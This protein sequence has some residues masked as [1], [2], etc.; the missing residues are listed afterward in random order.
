[1]SSSVGLW[2]RLFSCTA[3]IEK[4]VQRRFAKRGT[5]LARFDLLAALDR[6][7]D[8]M[9]MGALS[10]A[11]LVSN[12]NVTQL[13]QKLAK[14]GLV[15]I[16]PSPADRRVSI[17]RLAPEGR[18]HFDGL[19]AAHRDWID[20]LLAGMDAQARETLYQA[21]GHLKRSI[22]KGQAFGS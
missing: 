9:T 15:A 12:G 6:E 8:G 13:V 11:L 3:L 14:D 1:M 2:L 22:A 20:A 5:S 17:V 7:S 18:A 21:L 4:Q 16:A 19:A 10:R